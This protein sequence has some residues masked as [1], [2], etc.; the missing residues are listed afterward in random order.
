MLKPIRE[1]DVAVVG[2]GPTGLAA[3][4]AARLAG[5]EVTVVERSLPPI[6][7]P[8]GEGIMPDGVAILER[9]GVDI[10]A[11][12]AVPF[13]GIEF[14]QGAL[15]ARGE[16]PGRPGLGVRR[17]ALH[18]AL[19][20][21]AEQLQI[22]LLW[23]REV[24]GLH[25][26]GL[27]LTRGLIRSRYVVGAD[28]LESKLRRALGLDVAPI[29]RRFGIRRHFE[30]RPWNDHVEVHF[31]TGCEA[32]VT[33]VGGDQVCIAVLIHDPRL[34][35]DDALELFPDLARR[36]EH[37]RAVDDPEGSSTVYRRTP[38]ITRGRV[39][40]IG[41]AAGSVDAITGAGVTLGLHEALSLAGALRT[42]DLS[43]YEADYRRLMRIPGG[44]SSIM[45]AANRRPGLRTMALRTLATAPWVLSQLLGLHTRAFPFSFHAHDTLPGPPMDGWIPPGRDRPGRAD[46]PT[47]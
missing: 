36:I 43:S 30:V 45:L 33:P 15:R 40:L 25:D 47:A 27:E 18:A 21:R 5:L 17:T 22:E 29:Y 14:V 9:L 13:T 39:A 10:P 46:S 7:K 24:R 20:R 41:D 6:D 34:R 42:G 23:G 4:I 16:F 28:G 26:L 8:C 3:A 1:T 11:A 12:E 35:Y 37:A 31:A 32:Y 2:G 38:R 19:Q 44:M